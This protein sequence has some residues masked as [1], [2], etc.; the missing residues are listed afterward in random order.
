MN[1]KTQLLLFSFIL[2]CSFTFSQ[3]NF[4]V[5]IEI[6][7][8][9]D[10]SKLFIDYFDGKGTQEPKV[11]Y[12]KGIV[13]LSAPYFSKYAALQ[14]YYNHGDVYSAS[15]FFLTA[16]Q[17]TIKLDINTDGSL[18]MAKI[19]GAYTFDELGRKQ[20]DEYTR[21]ELNAIK[22][23]TKIFIKNMDKDSVQRKYGK[24]SN[25]LTNKQLQFIKL[26][27]HLYYSFY[28]FGTSIL[29]RAERLNPDTLNNIFE[30]A[31][32]EEYQ[33]SYEGTLFLKKILS[34]KSLKIGGLAPYFE[35]KDIKNKNI[36]LSEFSGQYVILDFWASWC[37]PCIEEIP[38]IK[39]IFNKYSRDKVQVISISRD[40]NIELFNRA[41][42]K[43][44]MKWIHILNDNEMI[45]K[46]QAKGVPHVFVID[47]E[48]YLIYSRDEMKDYKGDL[49]EL[50][51]LLK[52]KIN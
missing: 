35:T 49:S 46:F 15:N 28:H 9:I 34:Q 8:E 52:E 24:L 18:K 41:I 5:R 16:R 19:T 10:T 33:K 11:K 29:E 6:S 50:K 1:A 39:E 14:V 3:N 48:G 2:I 17:A 27:G 7:Q 23:Y 22:S 51:K 47:P 12:D 4:K 20:M 21:S 44:D 32:S 43:Y 38:A 25:L 30:K 45:E 31:F 36:S 26:N 40:K 37:G 42:A 13:N